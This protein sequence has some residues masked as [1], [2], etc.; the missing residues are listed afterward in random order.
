MIGVIRSIRVHERARFRVV[1]GA[2]E[3]PLGCCYEWWEV[4]GDGGR[5][6]AVGGVEVSVGEVVAHAGDVDPGDVGLVCE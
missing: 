4:V 1:I 6:D 3:E 5:D 2:C